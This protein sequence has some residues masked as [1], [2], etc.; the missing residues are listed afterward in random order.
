MRNV[1]KANYAAFW[2]DFLP[3]YLPKT[4]LA[5]AL[6]TSTAQAVNLVL[7]MPPMIFLEHLADGAA[8]AVAA[9]D[10]LFVTFPVCADSHHAGFGRWC[11]V[12]TT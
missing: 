12:I 7:Q 6:R 3:T 11:L 9:A 8:G 4:G 10:H 2:V 5:R 1:R